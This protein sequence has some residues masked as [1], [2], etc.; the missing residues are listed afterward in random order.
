MHDDTEEKKGAEEPAPDVRAAIIRCFNRYCSGIFDHER[1]DPN[2]LFAVCYELSTR[3]QSP[4]F[5]NNCTRPRIIAEVVYKYVERSPVTQDLLHN[6]ERYHP[7]AHREW[8]AFS[9]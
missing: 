2:Q 9:C 3:A 5:E 1:D 4:Q 7:D 6:I 8:V